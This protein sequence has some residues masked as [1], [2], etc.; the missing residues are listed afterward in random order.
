MTMLGEN[1]LWRGQFASRIEELAA[2]KA[3]GAASGA[4]RSTLNM[5]R[6][7]EEELAVDDLCHIIEYFGL[8]LSRTQYEALAGL[9]DRVGMLDSLQAAP[10][11]PRKGE[12]APG[13]TTSD[14]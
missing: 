1:E 10:P 2:S 9:A 6:S 5:S 14:Q 8:P 7:A 12:S 11:L 4:L 3:G 13:M